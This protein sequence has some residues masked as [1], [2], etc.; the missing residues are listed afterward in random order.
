MDSER[1]PPVRGTLIVVEGLDRAG[2]STQC[3]RLVSNLEHQGHKV[4]HM[5]FPGI[6]RITNA[7]GAVAN[8]ASFT[9][10][11][12]TIG[13]MIDTYLKNQIQ[14]DDHV[15]HLLFSANRWEAA[16]VTAP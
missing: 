8:Q 13:S 3:A 2:K 15:I 14:S 6:L 4:K 12:T 9:D 10:R 7:E 11:T 1:P 5:R 16:Y